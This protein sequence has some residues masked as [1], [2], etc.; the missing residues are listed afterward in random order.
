MP[1]CLTIACDSCS[2]GPSIFIE[3]GHSA[4]RALARRDANTLT[5]CPANDVPAAKGGNLSHHAKH[6][7]SGPPAA[8]GTALHNNRAIGLVS[9]QDRA[10]RSSNRPGGRPVARSARPAAKASDTSHGRRTARLAYSD[11][12]ERSA[13][14]APP[15]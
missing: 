1:A 5:P 2:W 9:A 14:A 11:V 8:I 4:R 6:R 3:D 12:P 7:H 15:R 13:H 10:Q